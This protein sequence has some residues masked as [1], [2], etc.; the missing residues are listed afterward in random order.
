MAKAFSCKDA[1]VNCEFHAQANTKEELMEKIG[2]H[3][4]AD[5]GME[6]V[7]PELMEKIEAGIRDL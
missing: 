5:H 1:G 3:A 6:T 4:K 7:P 2:A